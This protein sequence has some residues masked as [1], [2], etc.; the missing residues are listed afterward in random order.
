MACRPARLAFGVSRT[1]WGALPLPFP[2]TIIGAPGCFI[3]TSPDIVVGLR[4]NTSGVM[5][6]KTTIPPNS[7]F[8]GAGFYNHALVIDKGANAAGGTWTRGGFGRVG[9]L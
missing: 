8:I 5:D 3:N 6:F 9:N 1:R 2:L 7:A 4:A